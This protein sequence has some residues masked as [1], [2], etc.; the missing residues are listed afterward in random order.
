MHTGLNASF[1]FSFS[2]KGASCLRGVY[3]EMIPDIV[4]H[5][6]EMVLRCY[7]D[8]EGAPLYSLKWYRGKHEFYRYSPSEDVKIKIFNEH[9]FHVDVSNF[10]F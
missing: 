10:S 3:L 5:G 9:L 8:L 7:Y 4:E 2:P 1:L 6:R